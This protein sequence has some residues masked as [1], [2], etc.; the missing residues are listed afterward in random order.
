MGVNPGLST[1]KELVG[2]GPDKLLMQ[3]HLHENGG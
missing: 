1:V 2:F 3:K